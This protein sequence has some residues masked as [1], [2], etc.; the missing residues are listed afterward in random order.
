MLRIKDKN[1]EEDEKIVEMLDMKPLQIDTYDDGSKVMYVMRTAS[2]SKFE[3]MDLSD[4]G[5]DLCWTNVSRGC[6]VRLLAP[7]EK[8]ML[9][10]YNE[11]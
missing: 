2:T 7:G 10:L 4:P 3:V 1:S 5:A 8:I 9:E 6:E 11:E